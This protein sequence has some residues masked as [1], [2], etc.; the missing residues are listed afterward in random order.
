MHHEDSQR[1]TKTKNNV[2]IDKRN[3]SAKVVKDLIEEKK[4]VETKYS[5]MLVDVH[6]FMD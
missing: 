3:D 5:T 6:K 4:K 1:C 2:R